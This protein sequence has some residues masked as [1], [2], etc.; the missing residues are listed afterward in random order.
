MIRSGFV[1][2]AQQVFNR[3]RAYIVAPGVACAGAMLN[4]RS[5]SEDANPENSCKLAAAQRGDGRLTGAD[6]TERF[7]SSG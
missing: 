3:S 1:R 4:T 7:L 6:G 5:L 2:R